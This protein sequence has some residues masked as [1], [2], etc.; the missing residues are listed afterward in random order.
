MITE[1][2]LK[3]TY[4]ISSDQ[5]DFKLEYDLRHL[6]HDFNDIAGKQ[7]TVMG[8]DAETIGEKYNAMW[9]VSRLRV[10]MEKMPKWKDVVSAETYPLVPG[11]L[12][13]EREAI[14]RREDGTP[15][16]ILGSEWCILDKKTGVPRRPSLIGYPSENA[17]KERVMLAGYSD[18]RINTDE[19]DF[20]FSHTARV[21]DLDLNGHF[22]N[23]AYATLAVDAFSSA[24]L[25]A[26]RIKSFEIAFKAQSYE[27]EILKVYRRDEGDKSAVYCDKENGTR[28]FETLFAFAEE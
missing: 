7:A 16:A 5:A 17:V 23:V 21:S 25:K 4:E 26:R 8:V 6:L 1:N 15:F 10:I 3:K 27:G 22:N 28:V 11:I 9:I 13:M 20:A 24:E 18:T 2:R 19:K 12:R 14:F